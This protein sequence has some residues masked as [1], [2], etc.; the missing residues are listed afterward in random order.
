LVRVVDDRRQPH[1]AKAH[2]GDVAGV[3]EQ[4]AEVAAQVP[5]VGAAA[6]GCPGHRQVEGR[7]VA[8][9]VA[10]VVG[11]IA[12]DE[13]VGE[14]EIDGVRREGLTGAVVLRI[15]GRRRAHRRDGAIHRLDTMGARRQEPRH[16]HSR[17]RGGPPRR[18]ACAPGSRTR[19][20]QSP[21]TTRLTPPTASALI[22]SPPRKVASRKPSKL[23][24]TSCG[25]TMKKLKMPMYTPILAAGRLSDSSA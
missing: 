6:L 23:A 15:P 10:M 14:D 20:V 18:H 22:G 9:L 4:A 24:A 21:A 7:V 2:A 1:G 11:R 12:V 3:V 25:M 19:S 13:T 5:Y 17:E 8:A 16:R